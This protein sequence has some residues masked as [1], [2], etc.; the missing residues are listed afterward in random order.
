MILDCKSEIISKIFSI[1][2]T[3]TALAGRAKEAAKA[4]S[5]IAIAD[6]IMLKKMQKG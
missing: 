3:S 1:G 6:F 2:D 5:V 4:K